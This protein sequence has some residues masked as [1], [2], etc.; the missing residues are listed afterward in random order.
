M[1]NRKRWRC[2]FCDEVFTDAAAA[3]EHFGPECD[4][5]VAC[6]LNGMEGGLLKLYREAQDELRTYRREDNAAYREFYAIGADHS[7]KLRQ[8]EEQGYERGL[9][10]GRALVDPLMNNHR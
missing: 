6:K 9:K 10:D 4:G 5:I 7:V 2:F 1:S 8:A 3:A